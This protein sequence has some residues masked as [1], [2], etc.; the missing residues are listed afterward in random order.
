[1]RYLSVRQERREEKSGWMRKDKREERTTKGRDCARAGTRVPSAFTG[2]L[3][4]Q[5]DPAAVQAG[6]GTSVKTT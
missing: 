6:R 5:A 3:A 1:M 2:S 4:E